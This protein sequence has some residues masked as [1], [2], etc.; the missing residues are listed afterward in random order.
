MNFEE[1]D[2]LIERM[3]REGEYAKVDIILDNKINEILM[4]D[5]AEISKYLFLY[6]SLAG[7]MESLDRFDRLFEQAVALG[8]ANKSDLK[9]YENLSPANRWL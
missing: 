3:S 5:E 6:A 7:D 2:Q 9:M 8:K 4:L 1:F